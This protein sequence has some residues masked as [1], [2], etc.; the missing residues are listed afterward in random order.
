MQRLYRIALLA[1]MLIIPA[2]P[3][4]AQ[5]STNPPPTGLSLGLLLLGM[6]V[7]VVVGVVS[8]SRESAG[9]NNENQ[10]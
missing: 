3:A 2:T 8:G 10:Q 4:L 1:A 9:E 6:G 5:E 7:L